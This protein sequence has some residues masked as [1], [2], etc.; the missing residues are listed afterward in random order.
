MVNKICLYPNYTTMH[1]AYGT[2]KR[3]SVAIMEDNNLR[4]GLVNP[5]IDFALQVHEHQE[6]LRKLKEEEDDKFE[7]VEIGIKLIVNQAM[8]YYTRPVHLLRFELLL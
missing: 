1:H 5:C 3:P 8:Y 6:Q 2:Q 4:K 7:Q